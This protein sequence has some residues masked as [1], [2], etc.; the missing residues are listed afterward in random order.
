MLLNFRFAVCMMSGML[1]FK[2]FFT[3]GAMVLFLW[4]FT[5]ATTYTG[6]GLSWLPFS[7]PLALAFQGTV[8]TNV[9]FW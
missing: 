6:K 2:A 8:G 4:V 5:S 9:R 1:L 3:G 7:S